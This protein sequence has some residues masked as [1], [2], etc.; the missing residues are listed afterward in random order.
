MKKKEVFDKIRGYFKIE[1][2]HFQSKVVS[3][4]V[5][6]EIKNED[7]AGNFGIR[8]QSFGNKYLLSPNNSSIIIFTLENNFRNLL[9]GAII[10]KYGEG[11]LSSWP[12]DVD[13]MKK[14]RDFRFTDLS[15]LDDYLPKLKRFLQQVEQEFL[16]PFS[17]VNNIAKYIAQY[18]FSEQKN[19]LVGGQYPVHMMKKIFLLFQGNQMNRYEEYKLGLKKSIDSFGDQYPDEKDEEPLLKESYTYFIERLEAIGL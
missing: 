4:T 1:L 16:I 14:I 15:A 7:F 6:F 5:Q 10:S 17:D 18:P 3:D 8:C 13:L 19:I 12:N 2:P 9:N 11:T